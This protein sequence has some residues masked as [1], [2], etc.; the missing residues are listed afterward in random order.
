MQEAN[1]ILNN[2]YQEPTSHYATDQ[3]G[4]LDYARIVAG[5][6]VFVPEIRTVPL[7][8]SGQTSAFEI[9]DLREEY[10]DH[11]VNMMRREVGSW[12]EARWPQTTR[13]TRE[14]LRY[15]FDNPDRAPTQ[16]LFFAQR[17]ALESAIWLNEVADSTNAGQHL[18]NLLAECWKETAGLPRIAFKMATGT[19]KT[20]VMAA[21][22]LYNFFNRREY[23][24]DTRFADNFLVIAPGITIRDRLGVL[25]ADTLR[26]RSTDARDYYRERSL[27]SP[28]WEESL[29][30][31]NSRIVITNYH[32]F[33]SKTLQ[34][35]K[36]SPFDGKRGIDG[37]K[38]EAREDYA[39]VLKRVT[40]AF[41]PGSRL[42]VLNDE[43]HHCYLPREDGQVAEGEDTREENKRAAVWFKGVQELHKRFKVRWI[44]DLSATPYY[45]TGSGY[46][47]YSLFGWA[48]SDFGLIEAIES[49]LVKIPYLPERDDT[50][51]LD[52][53]VLKNLYEHIKDD[54]PRK[55]RRRQRADAKERGKT[56][57]DEAPRLPE[58]LKIA[59]QQFY[60]HYKEEYERLRDLFDSPP[61]FIVV[62]NNTT[63]SR[64]VFRY[65]AGYER[66]LPDGEIRTVAGQ[67]P[68]FSNFD[69]STGKAK[70]KAPT[71]LIDSDALEQL[72]QVSTE[73]RKVFAPEIERFKEDY[74]RLHGAGAAENLTDTELLR[75]VVNTVGKPGTLGEHIRCVVSVSMLTEGW[76]ANT[77]T[78]IV[79]I[80]AFG[81]QLLCEQI[82]GRALRRK[83]YVLQGYDRK[84]R[85]TEDRRRIHSYRY[86]PEYAHIIGVPFK[87]F[88][89]GKT[90]PA[91]PQELHLVRAL[92]E[93]QERCE[94]RFPNLVG[95][96]IDQPR[97]PIQADFS[98]IDP[99]EIGPDIPT[100]TR[101]CT[102]VTADE[103]VLSADEMRE[104]RHQQVIYRITQQLL[105]RQFRDGDNNVEFA[106]FAQAR[107]VVEEWYHTRVVCHGD[108]FKQ[109]LWHFDPERYIGGIERAIQ[110]AA[111]PDSRILPVLR[112]NNTE[113][114]TNHV[115]GQ[116]SRPVLETTHS[117]VNYVVADTKSWEQIAAKSLEE[118]AEEGR[119][120]S[121]VKNAFLGFAVPYVHEDED[122]L[123]FPDFLIRLPADNGV[124]RTLIL[125]VT[126]MNKDKEAK[127]WYVEHRW[128]PAVNAAAE[129]HGWGRWEFLEVAGEIKDIKN[130][131]RSVIQ[132]L[133]SEERG[134]EC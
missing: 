105:A 32:Q 66:M 127:R 90:T 45:L 50:Q 113:G 41:R 68:L 34:G 12:R 63:V 114:S 46:T 83:H 76:D 109:L 116:T 15:W 52:D 77:V 4:A 132:R 31:L 37:K 108:C 98:E 17:E 91:A 6:R 42:L 38:R 55:G 20:V 26:T 35:N 128:L 28:H 23:R 103:T 97:S 51:Q 119:I 24:N 125:E 58:T 112:M 18:L 111:N 131:L 120:L 81:S 25:K 110:T 13:V 60:R 56:F 75:E 64:D 87:L 21:L 19:G 134:A 57:E 49:G 118:L 36:R 74:A 117:H 29:R 1:P 130:Q 61:V 124:E 27:V 80:R 71:L 84:G 10:A 7:R 47:P 9:N 33:L 2:P 11:I 115:R 3:D 79:G 92:P 82:A 39:Q 100:V 48:V 22:I 101:M 126:G 133:E 8:Q 44:H 96:R 14:L 65:L 104:L 78:H 70:R 16:Q 69:P 102:A 123:Y 99:F 86:P 94:I 30:E 85:F 122:R 67:L 73:F 54:L 72:D 53:P 107:D 40:G 89:G 62:C 129:R 106:R 95:Y 93:R 88:R 43:A 59:L 121:Y 5:R